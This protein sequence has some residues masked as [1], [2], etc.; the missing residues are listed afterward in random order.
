MGEEAHEAKR[1]PVRKLTSHEMRAGLDAR[2]QTFE[3][4]Y[5]MKSGEMSLAFSLGLVRETAEIVEWMQVYHAR[6]Y[7]N[8]KTPTTGIPMT[9]TEPSTRSA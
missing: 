2:I 6:K 3:Q 7:L 8:E 9:T 1:I 5:E 4:R